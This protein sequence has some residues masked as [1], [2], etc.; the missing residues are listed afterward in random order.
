MLNDAQF[1]GVNKNREEF[2]TLYNNFIKN[3]ETFLSYNDLINNLIIAF[4]NN[5]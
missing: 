3:I 4:H 1:I 2:I 5:R